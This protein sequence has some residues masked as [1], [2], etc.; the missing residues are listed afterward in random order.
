MNPSHT[1]SHTPVAPRRGS[2]SA[3][4]AMTD[5]A[6]LEHVV[7][8]DTVAWGTFLARFRN[9]IV[10]CVNRVAGR[11]GV[12]MQPDDASE[13]LS[14]VCL[15]LIA[16]RYRRLRMYRVDGGCS[17]A[18][19]IG[20]I[21]TSTTHDYLRRARRRRLDP[22]SEADLEQ[23]VPPVDPP[24][25]ELIERQRRSR[26]VSVLALLSDRDRKFVELYFAEARDPA[27]VARVLG[28]S[29]NTVYS[30]KAKIKTRLRTLAGL[31]A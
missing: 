13:V 11:A 3:F 31:A 25:L 30:K 7:Q 8:G 29:I 10:S 19:W 12:W 15:N 4:D 18:S 1:P 26:A 16:D 28:V 2:R 6:L 22:T 14:D 20:V 23:L 9:L 5:L 27:D 17:V 24:D 21:A